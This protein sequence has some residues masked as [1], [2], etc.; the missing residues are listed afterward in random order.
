VRQAGGQPAFDR[1]VVLFVHEV[2]KVVG[3]SAA[4]FEDAY[5]NGWMPTLAEGSDARLAWYFDLAHGSG[6]AYRVVTVTAVKDG[7]AWSRLAERLAHGDLQSWARDLDGLQHES[8]GR[9]MTP[10]AWSPLLESLEDIPTNPVV[11]EPTMYMEDTMWPFPGK[12]RE[13]IRAAG[14]V[15][16]RTLAAEGS[17][18]QMHIEL[19]LQS[20][21]GAGRYPEVTLMQKL[22][23]LPPLIRLL[24]NDMPTE[25]V[26]AGSWMDQALELRDQWQSRL[27]RTAVWSPLQ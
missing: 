5:R 19:A 14:D 4:R 13:Y 17:Q 9:I 25:V 8:G 21:P 1:G 24:T 10:L 20:M 2:H 6:L 18:V 26:Q 16:Q 7:A 22:S 12:V 23:S 15:Y 27:L 3:K 11:H